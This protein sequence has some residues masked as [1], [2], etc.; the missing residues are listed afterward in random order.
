MLNDTGDNEI[1]GVA[2]HGDR[3]YRNV[4]PVAAH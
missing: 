4:L 3:A 2:A 1:L